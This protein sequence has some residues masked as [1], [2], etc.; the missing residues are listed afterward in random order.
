MRV[1]SL[2]WQYTRPLGQPGD[3][4]RLEGDEWHHCYS[5]LRLRVDEE[6]ILTDGLGTCILAKIFSTDTRKGQIKLLEDVSHHFQNPRGYRL[7][8]AFAPTKNIDRTEMAIEKITELGVDEI[9]FLDC[10]HGER[11]T[12]RMDRIE[13]IV[14]GAAKQ[15]RKSVF[16]VLQN[17]TT[18][19]AYIKQKQ[20]DP[21]TPA[22]FACHLDDSSKPVFEN[23]S[24]GQDVVMLIGPEGGFSN[25]EVN[26]MCESKVNLV[27]LGP[28]R[29]RVETAVINACSDIHLINEMK[30]KS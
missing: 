2:P 22:I 26:M 25:E 17:L 28:F 7:S 14:A 29:L 16:P 27:H 5:V 1:N 13:K 30:F 20:E 23:Y 19:K 18:P 6:L 15:S 8:I 12:I 4:I 21:G 24:A 10:R 11:G 9:C 3:I